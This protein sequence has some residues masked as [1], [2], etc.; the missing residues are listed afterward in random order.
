MIQDERNP[1]DDLNF[2]KPIDT[3]NPILTRRGAEKLTEGYLQH[4]HH[5]EPTIGPQWAPLNKFFG[6]IGDF[7]WMGFL[8]QDGHRI[9][10]YKQDQTRSYL[11]I[12]EVGNFYLPEQTNDREDWPNT[13]LKDDTTKMIIVS[14][15]E[16]HFACYV[17]HRS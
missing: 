12:D 5:E 4:E 11:Y 3:S 1:K 10:A 7:A 16:A 2:I 8:L 6:M 15:E 14:F 13:W 17:P 9:E